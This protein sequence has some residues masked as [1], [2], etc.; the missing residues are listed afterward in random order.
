MGRFQGFAEAFPEI[1]PKE[2]KA[3]LVVRGRAQFTPPKSV[4]N[5]WPQSIFP[6]SAERRWQLAEILIRIKEFSLRPN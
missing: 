1:Q 5:K 2:G 6:A 4:R 3:F